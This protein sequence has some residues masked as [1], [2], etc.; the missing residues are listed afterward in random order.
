MSNLII[1]KKNEV[2]LKVQ[3]EPHISYELADYFTFEV[4]Q[5]KFRKG[6]M[7]QKVGWRKLGCTLLAL[8]NYMSVL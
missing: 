6:T 4:P 7:M 3:A 5:A 8:E 2:Y 1:R